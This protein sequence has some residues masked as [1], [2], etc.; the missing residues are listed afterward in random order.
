MAEFARE[1]TPSE[2]AYKNSTFLNGPGSRHI[3]ILCEYEEP[4]ERL[5]D[6]GI[7]AT[8]LFFGSDRAKSTVQFA[9]SETK[10]EAD[11]AAATASGESTENFVKEL[12]RLNSG[13]WMVEY[14][15]KIVDLSRKLTD[16]SCNSGIK[17]A[18]G[19]T[20]SGVNRAMHPHVSTAKEGARLQQSAVVCT[21]GGPGFMEAANK[22]ASLVPGA[23]NVGVSVVFIFLNLYAVF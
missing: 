15:D 8:I 21:G 19:R 13:A 16:W 23:I 4:H 10:L 22:G 6:H 18:Q 1:Y 3:R 9:E 7:K 5:K 12:A 17:L 20:L 11:I 2:K 14:Y